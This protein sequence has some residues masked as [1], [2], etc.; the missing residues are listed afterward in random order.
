MTN[1]SSAHCVARSVSFDQYQT[2]CRGSPQWV[3]DLYWFSGHMFKGQGQ[4][5]LL[6][7][8][9]CPLNIF[10]PLHLINTKDGHGLRPIV[11]SPY[12]FSGH[13]FKSQGQATLEHS[14]LST[15][16]I[17]I[18]CLLVFDRFCFYRD[19]APWGHICFWKVSC[20]NSTY[21]SARN[22]D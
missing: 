17:L 21:N 14:V 6:S 15:L 12:W 20:F 18:L 5:T 4:T 16:Y 19:F 13:M 11:D 7:P 1:H 10:W 22:Y 9:C 2:W 8:I 3:D